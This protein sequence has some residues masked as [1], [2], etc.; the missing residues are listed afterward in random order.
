M[1]DNSL[2]GL[3]ARRPRSNLALFEQSIYEI[4]VRLAPGCLKMVV[5]PGYN[6]WEYLK[7]TFLNVHKRYQAR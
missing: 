7:D 5:P 1:G 4:D 3:D 2:I 6:N